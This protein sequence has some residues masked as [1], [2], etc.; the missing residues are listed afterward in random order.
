MVIKGSAIYDTDNSQIAISELFL[1]LEKI[2]GT[3]NIKIN[4]TDEVDAENEE[5]PS[6][7]LYFM[8]FSFIN[9]R[10]KKDI[11]NDLKKN[12]IGFGLDE[13]IYVS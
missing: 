2:K 7:M 4:I 12:L 8:E 11:I 5:Y 6:D 9:N 3:S 10:N 13:N 1:N